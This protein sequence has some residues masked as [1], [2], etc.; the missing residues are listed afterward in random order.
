MLLWIVG[1]I[2]TVLRFNDFSW[3][4]PVPPAE[5]EVVLGQLVPQVL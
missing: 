1:L 2:R 4:K 3:E 5:V